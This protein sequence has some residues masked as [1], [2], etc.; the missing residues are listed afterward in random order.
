MCEAEVSNGETATR[1][2]D[3]GCERMTVTKSVTQ[4][5]SKDNY[6]TFFLVIHKIYKFQFAN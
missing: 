4:M 1:K 3:Q 6:N 2:V 5:E